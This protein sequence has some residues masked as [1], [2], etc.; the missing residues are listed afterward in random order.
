MLPTS[1]SKLDR[2]EKRPPTPPRDI[3]KAI[4]EVTGFLESANEVDDFVRGLNSS[5]KPD[6]AVPQSTP[7]SST[8]QPTVTGSKRVDFSPHLRYHK[9]APLGL[10]SS[11][12]SRLLK[13]SPSSKDA[14]PG[15]SILKQSTAPPPTPDELDSKL[16][17]FS[18]D[19]PGSFNK[20]LHSVIQQLGGPS[21]DAR[22]DAYRT[23]NNV[24]RAY[25][26]PP[27][28][29]PM[30][31]K[32]GVLMQFLTRDMAWK[33]MDGKLDS[34][35][36]SGALTLT[37]ALL[38]DRNLSDS[39][40]DDFRS[41]LVDRSISVLEQ[42]EMPKQ[43]MKQHM[44]LLAQSRF[45]PSVMTAAKADK[46]VTVLRTL[47]D[48]CN[49]NGILGLRL[50]VYTRMIE[51][52][53]NVMLSRVTD[54]L[55]HVFHG[56]VSSV[57]EIRQRAIE[58][59][60]SAG[61]ILG[62]YE[63]ASK[64][65]QEILQNDNEE[66]QTY[67]T[68]FTL[69]L[70]EMMREKQSEAQVPQIWSAIV[71]FYR[72]K[73]KPLEAWSKFKPWLGII[74]RCLNSSD[75]ST[76][77]QATVAWN[78]LVFAVM[79]D[80]S[81]S[82]NMLSMLKTPI[83]SGLEKRGNDN[84]SKQIRHITLDCYSNLLYYAFRPGFESE[85]YDRVWEKIVEP[86]LT[87]MVQASPKGR[88]ETCRILRGLLGGN[89]M[90]WNAN[91]A[92]ETPAVK[93]ED[94]P[95]LDPKW[96]RS[97]LTKLLSLLGPIIDAALRSSNGASAD[98]TSVWSLL[99]TS[100]V[101]AGVQEV[102]TTGDL[103]EAIALLVSLLRRVCASCVTA[104]TGRDGK[105]AS[106]LYFALL[107]TM[108]STMRPYPFI[109]D[110]LART[111]S[112]TIEV[113]P[114]PSHR[115]SK[116]HGPPLSPMVILL[117]QVYQRAPDVFYEGQFNANAKRLLKTF[118]SAKQTTSAKLELLAR[119]LHIWMEEYRAS[120]Q[121]LALAQAWSAVAEEITE[122][123]LC[124]A[125]T[126]SEGDSHMCSQDFRSAMSILEKGF[127]LQ[128]NQASLLPIMTSLYDAM[129]SAARS[130]AGDG[131]IVVAVIEPLAKALL[132]D[133][134]E[135]L[136][137]ESAFVKRILT[138]AV[139]PKSRKSLEQAQKALRIVSVVPQ[140]STVFDPYDRLYVLVN[141]TMASEYQN[142][143]AAEGYDTANCM[144][145]LAKVTDF[146]NNTPVSYLSTALRK[147]QDGLSIWVQDT[148][149]KTSNDSRL[150][151]TV[152]CLFQLARL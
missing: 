64:G 10:S 79:P 101:D 81:T 94:L 33:G 72:N 38:H 1:S 49:G 130:A 93:P 150:A 112:D 116:H 129:V 74:Q 97:R 139:W 141:G 92:F 57:A 25:E 22:L 132:E 140:K 31:E 114:T 61:T 26:E 5:D 104:N 151:Q 70:M 137:T 50:V 21:R 58:A 29:T 77:Y 128:S 133:V 7:T 98:L 73:R 80:S 23:L 78:R 135:D 82:P 142:L 44:G 53:P 89:A 86:V 126:N 109:E 88:Q 71:L 120:S 69:R 107:G 27:D 149:Q 6:H 125:L 41:F 60:T 54:W 76:R 8:L 100:L 63:R 34:H 99:M 39:L 32:M 59:C 14:R 138:D 43:T 84:F 108:L 28:A 3:A 90:I 45:R 152:G 106:E 145:L 87:Q 36:V 55:H 42:S 24:F 52:A 9:I 67:W 85:Q 122:Q 15:K 62:T 102:K 66:G 119:C 111:D 124:E 144:E 147:L 95:R 110:I 20:M 12:A 18:P 96:I 51:Q 143:G 11:P 48:R 16:S 75:F 46:L 127:S 148:A 117:G 30:K 91:V 134:C 4:E 123:L 136:P 56:M 65:L 35:I 47:E 17:Y 68:F 40:D 37:M 146:L 105:D 115:A 118:I 83:V 19:I 121:S 2:L 113:A 103:K 131:G 13:C